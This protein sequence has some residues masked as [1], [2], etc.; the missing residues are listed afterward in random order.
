MFTVLMISGNTATLGL[1]KISLF[2]NKDYDL[3]ISNHWGKKSLANDSNYIVDL[4]MWPKF[5]NSSIFKGEV[6][7]V[8]TL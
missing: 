3:I 2:R 7:T 4:S 1:L 5:L 8:S 6:V